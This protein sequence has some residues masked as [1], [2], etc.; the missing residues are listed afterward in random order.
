MIDYTA[1]SL[2]LF[3]DSENKSRIVCRITRCPGGPESVTIAFKVVV[4]SPLGTDVELENVANY[5]F[6]EKARY[7]PEYGDV[8]ITNCV[9]VS[10]LW[11]DTLIL[12]CCLE[13]VVCPI[14]VIKTY[15]AR[16]RIEVL[17]R[18]YVWTLKNYNSGKLCEKF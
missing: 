3:Q 2:S 4:I 6:I 10:A 11:K 14:S 13:K 12:K 17:K 5:T 16:S 18:D 8:S 9:P 7:P 15:F 1:W